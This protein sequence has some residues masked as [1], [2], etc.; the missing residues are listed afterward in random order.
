MRHVFL[1]LQRALLML[2]ERVGW[3]IRSHS[4]LETI[5]AQTI[6]RDGPLTLERYMQMALHHP[7]Y[8][9]YRRGSPIGKNGDFGTFPEISQLF[10]DMVGAWCYHAWESLGRPPEF[11][12]CELGPGRGTMLADALRLVNQQETFHQA[13]RLYLLE[14][15][16]TLRML[17]REK[18]AQYQPTYL[19]NLADLPPLPLILLANEFFDTLPIKQ[20]IKTPAGWREHLVTHDGKALKLI[21]AETTSAVTFLPH[22]AV[23]KDAPI[24]AVFET[25]PQAQRMMEQIAKHLH[26]HRGLA[27][28]IDYG[29]TK[30]T[31]QGS[32]TAW[33]LHG[34]VDILTAPGQVDVTANVDFL[35]LRYSAEQSGLRVDGPI[36]Q[37]DFIQKMGVM[38][39]VDLLKQ[40]A[41]ATTRQ[42]IDDDLKRLL[43][44]QGISRNF[45]V[46]SVRLP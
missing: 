42:A 35:A 44:P 20:F 4:S 39:R 40:H 12:L 19:E 32:L 29:Y 38:L 11:I 34:C 18:L 21:E 1:K 46:L 5:I 33:S 43:D 41:D 3:A 9:Y 24:G 7:D 27:L 2:A 28:I 16:Q 36:W 6:R 37:G 17:Q 30:P 22:Q 25:S 31:L 23:Y 10:T 26:Q 8:G 13:M 15:S 45:G 14:S